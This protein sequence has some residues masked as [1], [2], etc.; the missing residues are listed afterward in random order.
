MPIKCKIDREIDAKV[1]V[2][3]D[4]DSEVDFCNYLILQ[5]N[6]NLYMGNNIIGSMKL[7]QLPHYD[8]GDQQEWADT[9]CRYMI[10]LVEIKERLCDYDSEEFDE[11]SPYFKHHILDEFYIRPQYR[12]KGYAYKALAEGL[13]QAGCENSFIYLYPSTMHFEREERF[14]KHEKKKKAPRL[15]TTQLRKFYKN[16]SPHV[17]THKVE[18]GIAKKGRHKGKMI[19]ETYL[20]VRC[21]NFN[22]AKGV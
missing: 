17:S 12:G 3:V 7:Y 18:Q 20:T 4:V 8:D 5:K 9:K 11:E 16:M 22:T 2:G 15:N 13:K 6:V 1:R 14:M 21:W 19:N 10:D